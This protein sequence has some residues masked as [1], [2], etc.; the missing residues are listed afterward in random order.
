MLA[1]DE[2]DVLD[3]ATRILLACTK[4]KSV[5]SCQ[6]LFSGLWSISSCNL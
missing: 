5:V 6:S 4:N 2:V 1:P 3:V